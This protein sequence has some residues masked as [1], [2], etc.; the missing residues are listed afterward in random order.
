[1]ALYKNY[2][3]R[4]NSHAQKAPPGKRDF[5]DHNPPRTA[6]ELYD[7]YD[8]SVGMSTVIVLGIMLGVVVIRVSIK[9]I[10]RSIRRRLRKSR[11]FKKYFPVNETKWPPLHVAEQMA[12]EEGI[13]LPK[14]LILK[15]TAEQGNLHKIVHDSKCHAWVTSAI[16]SPLAVE[17]KKTAGASRRENERSSRMSAGTI[18]TSG[19]KKKLEMERSLSLDRLDVEKK[20][21]HPSAVSLLK[22]HDPE[23]ARGLLEECEDSYVRSTILAYRR[24][25][26]DDGWVSK[27]YFV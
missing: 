18:E 14:S 7:R 22:V 24:A 1:M 10:H 17:E 20:N 23:D 13:Q 11:L 4:H 27:V 15:L 5:Q 2:S 25:S 12:R 19:Q 21:Q 3:I 8:P 16:I 26:L 9:Y 6:Q